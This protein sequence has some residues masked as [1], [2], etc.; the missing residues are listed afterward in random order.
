MKKS[1]SAIEVANYQLKVM[2]GNRLLM[3]GYRLN[4]KFVKG[5]ISIDEY[6]RQQ[7]QIEVDSRKD[8]SMEGISFKWDDLKKFNSTIYD[9]EIAHYQVW[10][11]YGINAELYKLKNGKEGFYVLDS[12]RGKLNGKDLTKEMIIDIYKEAY[13]APFVKNIE[14]TLHDVQDIV[15]YEILRGTIQGLRIHD[16]EQV[17]KKYRWIVPN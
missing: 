15:I 11:K 10:K 13:F 4:I 7:D 16:F 2:L 9:H 5:E 6:F 17:F 12:F 3:R 8:K 1:L 14:L